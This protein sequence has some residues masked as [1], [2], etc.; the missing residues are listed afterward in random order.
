MRYVSVGLALLL[1]SWLPA[2]AQSS[3]EAQ[4]EERYVA[5]IVTE[6]ATKISWERR[7]ATA[8]TMAA[9]NK[10][11]ILGYFTRSYSP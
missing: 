7:L 3:R 6:F 9:E 8:Q 5:K 10:K 1:A 11:L 4:Y 2:A